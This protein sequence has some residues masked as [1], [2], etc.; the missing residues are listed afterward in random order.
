MDE[1]FYLSNMAPQVGDGFNRHCKTS[2]DTGGPLL[3]L[4]RL[5]LPRKLVQKTHKLILG[6]LYFHRAFVPPAA[7]AGWKV[8]SSKCISS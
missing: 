7:R 5:G 2:L 3:M 4:H 8:A 1:T 6:R